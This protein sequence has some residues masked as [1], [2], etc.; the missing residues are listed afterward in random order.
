MT[1]NCEAQKK[2]KSM[3]E[4]YHRGFDHGMQLA[5]LIIIIVVNLIYWNL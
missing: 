4:E 1:C 2:L 3:D 5:A